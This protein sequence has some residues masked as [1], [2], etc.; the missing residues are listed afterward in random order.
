[1]AAERDLAARLIAA[2]IAF[3]LSVA[4]LAVTTESA[5][6]GTLYLTSCSGF[7][8][9][10]T[11]TDVGGLVWQGLGA[12]SFGTP[13]RCPQGGSFQILP[14]GQPSTGDNVQWATTTPPSIQIVHAITPVNEVL[15]DPNISG[16][17]YRAEF[18]WN[19]GSQAIVPENNCCGGMDYGSGINTWLGPSRWFGW[20]VTCTSG[21]CGEPLQILDVRGVQLAAVDTTPPGVLALGL[22]NLWYQGGRWVRGSWPASFAASAD[23]GICGSRAIIDGNSIPGP[24]DPTPNQHSWT[25]CPTPVTMNMSVD[26]TQY[27]NGSLSYTLSAADAANPANVSSPSETIYVDNEPVSLSLSGPTDAPSTAGTQYVSA[28]ASA[29][30]SGVAGISCSV[31][32][33]PYQW[34]SGASAQIPVRGVGQ[35]QVVCYAQNNAI[36]SAGNP[37]VSPTETWTMSIRVP[38]ES[39]IG[40][41]R[42]VDAL[43][44]AKVRE[45][46]KVPA[47]YVL[48]RRHHKLVK[49]RRRARTKIVKAVRCH[50][51]TVRRKIVVLATV[52]RHGK[53]VTVK[54]TKIERVV[55]LPHAVGY[56]ARRVR[57]GHRTSISG[58]L[59]S[60]DGTALAGQPVWVMTAPDNGQERFTLARAVTT[61]SNGSWTSELAPGPSRLVEAVYPGAPTTEPSTSGQVR[62]VVPAIVRLHIKPRAV[63]W[64]GTIHIDGRVLGGYI[65]GN[66]QQLLRLRIGAEGIFSTVGIPDIAPNGRFHTTWRFH[67][68]VGVV[69]YWFSVSTLN[70]AD[71]PFAPASSR[72]VTVTVGPG[73]R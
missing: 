41:S 64:G 13:N 57:Y 12:G 44:C 20:Q 33:G 6:A 21:P 40:W 63:P 29:G 56:T 17:G 67:A 4:L 55:L 18:F 24:S 10:G 50:A 22:N 66:R 19:G 1:V 69:N 28:T 30:P 49:V 3:A 51:R 26:T 73:S 34:H 15:I 27:A 65:P 48:V 14:A 5:R 16:D 52:K 59:G 53:T 43:R 11:D 70:E 47:H 31:D 37:T 36:D 42:T 60:Y 35:H 58:W 61:A 8:D 46:V 2:L 68:G 38:T 25:Q 72:R 45:R 32:G 71:Y 7:G 54:R 23:D 39:G 9:G 62:I